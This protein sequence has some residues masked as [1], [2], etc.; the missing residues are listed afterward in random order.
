[1]DKYEEL[2]KL[3]DLKQKGVISEDEFNEKKKLILNAADAEVNPASGSY[4]A[5]KPHYQR[6]FTKFD[7]IIEDYKRTKIKPGS[8]KFLSWNWAAFFFSS[9]WALFKAQWVLFLISVIGNICA[10]AG[11][12][13]CALYGDFYEYY[14]FKTGKTSLWL[15]GKAIDELAEISEIK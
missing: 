3:N 5:I 4:F 1:M 13:L 10:G 2:E 8:T 15:I 14:K 7:N 6:A 11:T 12:L 9:L